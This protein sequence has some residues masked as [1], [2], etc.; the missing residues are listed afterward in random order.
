MTATVATVTRD[1]AN[2]KFVCTVNGTSIGASKHEDYFEYHYR[3]GDIARLNNL[4]IDQFAYMNEDGSVK[5]IKEAKRAAPKDQPGTAAPT[6]IT[7][8]AAQAAPTTTSN[9]D[10]EQATH[11]SPTSVQ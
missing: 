2:N 8:E 10:E 3:R 9:G 6:A 4:Q 7:V 1:I 11:P 5:E